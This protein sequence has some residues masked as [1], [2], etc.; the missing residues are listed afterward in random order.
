M[1]DTII[2]KCYCGN[3]EEIELTDELKEEINNQGC[4]IEFCSECGDN[5]N[6]YPV[7]LENSSL[8][9]TENCLDDDYDYYNDEDYNLEDD[10]NYDDKD[11]Y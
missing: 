2:K 8:Y 7:D 10:P 4:A 5:L 1:Y 9:K 6:L 3:K 11:D